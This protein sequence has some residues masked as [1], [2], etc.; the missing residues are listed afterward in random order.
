MPKNVNVSS[1]EES[2][3]FVPSKTWEYLS[4]N[5]E[6]ALTVI[7]IDPAPELS[8]ISNVISTVATQQLASTD[9]TTCYAYPNCYTYTDINSISVNTSGDTITVKG[10]S[11]SKSLP[12]DALTGQLGSDLVYL[13][14]SPTKVSGSG[15]SEVG[16]TKVTTDYNYG[17][18]IDNFYN[19]AWEEKNDRASTRTSTN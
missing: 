6:S 2:I 13:A 18:T 7:S 11:G 17:T 3:V 16:L 10:Y 8:T 5:A 19:I 1:P 12:T 9:S 15:S 14:T 4:T